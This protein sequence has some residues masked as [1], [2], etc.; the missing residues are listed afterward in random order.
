MRLDFGYPLR[1]FNSTEIANADIWAR[2]CVDRKG[3]KEVPGDLGYREYPD[4]VILEPSDLI[5]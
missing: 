2:R 5:C 3:T 4:I 1:S